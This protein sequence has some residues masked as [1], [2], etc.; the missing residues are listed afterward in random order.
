MPK[1]HIEKLDTDG[2]E[3]GRVDVSL[4]NVH[5]NPLEHQHESDHH[6]EG[7]GQDLHS[8]MAMDEGG[9]S[10]GTELH[11]DHGDHDGDCHDDEVLRQSDG[12]NDG[13]DGEDDIQDH[14]L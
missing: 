10:T 8:R 6:Q 7:Q 1:P 9:Y 14:D 4:W 3:H 5:A 13:I 12:G 2:K 11:D